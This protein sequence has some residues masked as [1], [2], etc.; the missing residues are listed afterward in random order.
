MRRNNVVIYNIPEES[1]GHG[2]YDC[3]GFVQN[4]LKQ[5]MKMD[6]ADKFEIER[7]HRS[8]TGPPRD[9][10]VRPITVKFLRYQDRVATLKQASKVLKNSPY[11][12]N[13]IYVSDDVT[14]TVRKDRKRLVR[15]KKLIKATQPGKRVFIPNVVPAVLL[16]E[17]DAGTLMRFKPGEFV[18]GIPAHHQPVDQGI[19]Q[20]HSSAAENTVMME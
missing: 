3:S 13:N 8:P 7:A 17:D 4:F 19:D 14:E 10:K 18:P 6:A 2:V 1:E 20:G 11:R 9:R 12:G 15:I 5:H 16:C